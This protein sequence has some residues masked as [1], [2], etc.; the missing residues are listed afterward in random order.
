MN[1]YED[2]NEYQAEIMHGN[3]TL[4]GSENN[5]ESDEAKAQCQWLLYSWIW[6]SEERENLV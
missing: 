3:K 4:F 6:I 2:R 1:E 5:D